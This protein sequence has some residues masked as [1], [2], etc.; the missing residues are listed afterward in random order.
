M[1]I[2]QTLFVAHAHRVYDVLAD[3]FYHKTNDLVI[4]T[5]KGEIIKDKTTITILT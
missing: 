3:E 5:L 2:Y 1:S 4:N